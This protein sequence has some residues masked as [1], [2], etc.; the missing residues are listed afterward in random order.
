[1]NGYIAWDKRRR[2]FQRIKNVRRANKRNSY[3]LLF[4][5]L[6]ICIASFYFYFLFFFANY[7][8]YYYYL[9]YLRLLKGWSAEQHDGKIKKKKERKKEEK[10][11]KMPLV[12]VWVYYYCKPKRFL[13]RTYKGMFQMTSWSHFKQ[14]H[15]STI[16][17]TWRLVC[18]STLPHEYPFL[19][20][21]QWLLLFIYL[22]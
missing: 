11:R 8:Y 15:L 4:P 7:Y 10:A 12:M 9:S 22:F 1:M 13:G 14:G 3:L 2:F 5:I 19:S 18:C 17:K 16:N 20:L 21:I 6:Q